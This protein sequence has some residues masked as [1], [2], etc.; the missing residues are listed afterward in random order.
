MGAQVHIL[1]LRKEPESGPAN[2]DLIRSSRQAQPSVA[3]V[4]PAGNKDRAYAGHK[5]LTPALRWKRQAEW[6][7]VLSKN[8]KCF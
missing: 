2:E 4:G 6:N 8:G 1:Q 3:P 5:F 7:Q